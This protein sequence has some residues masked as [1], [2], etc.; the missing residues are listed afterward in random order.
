MDGK[1]AIL[2]EEYLKNKTRLLEL[3]R[4]PKKYR[5][6]Q[7]EEEIVTLEDNIKEFLSMLN[8]SELRSLVLMSLDI[9]EN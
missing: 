4:L 8:A 2:L 3:K 6:E 5:S 7:M 1:K 9:E